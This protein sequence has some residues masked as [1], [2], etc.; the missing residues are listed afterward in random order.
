MPSEIGQ[1]LVVDD[2]LH[3]REFAAKLLERAG[4]QVTQAASGDEAIALARSMPDLTLVVADMEMP[5][6]NG[7]Q[8]V[9]HMRQHYPDVMIVMATVYDDVVLIER[10]FKAGIDIF[11]V[12]PNGFIELY[13]HLTTNRTDEEFFRQPWIADAGGLRPYRGTTAAAASW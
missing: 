4:F 12:K 9:R 13:K 11:M 6:M 2:E 8:V 1:A 7:L 5:S 3:N 10:A